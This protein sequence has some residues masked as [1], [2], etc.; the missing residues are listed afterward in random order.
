MEL[1]RSYELAISTTEK[2]GDICEKKTHSKRNRGQKAAEKE[3][4][5]VSVKR[6]EG[7]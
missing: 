4:V 2:G 3:M 1:K 6:F 5:L 7:H